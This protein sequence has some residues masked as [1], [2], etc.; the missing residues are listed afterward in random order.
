MSV[1]KAKYYVYEMFFR[2]Q[3]I[4]VQL[5]TKHNFSNWIKDRNWSFQ[6]TIEL[7]NFTW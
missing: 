3:D 2:C 6:V 4:L 1:N 5:H 7:K